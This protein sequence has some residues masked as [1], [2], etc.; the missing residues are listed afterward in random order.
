MP[1]PD[2][3]VG[4]LL[5]CR[6]SHSTRL[7][8]LPDRVHI[9][10]LA[11]RK[12]TLPLEG[13]ACENPFPTNWVGFTRFTSVIMTGALLVLICLFSQC[14]TKSSYN[15]T[16]TLSVIVLTCLGPPVLPRSSRPR[17]LFS[18]NH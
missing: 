4:T 14:N 12:S 8:A 7:I 15:H 16:Y 6:A 17:I 1:L 9:Y 11:L 5:D 3:M 13:R 10:A 18:H 2:T